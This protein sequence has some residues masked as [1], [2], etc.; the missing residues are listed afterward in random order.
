MKKLL[1]ILLLA[2]VFISCKTEPKVKY[3]KGSIAYQ[4]NATDDLF[5]KNNTHV[6]IIGGYTPNHKSWNNGYWR[7]SG[8]TGVIGKWQ[9][10]AEPNT[11]E[12]VKEL[13]FKADGTFKYVSVTRKQTTRENGTFEVF[14]KDGNLYLKL[15]YNNVEYDMLYLCSDNYFVHEDTYWTI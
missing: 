12:Y 5:E 1:F 15:K 3:S 13:E 9:R 6:G 14:K 8:N 10:L 7:I 11:T 4:N 2:L